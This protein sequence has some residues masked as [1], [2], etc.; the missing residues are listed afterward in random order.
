[1]IEECPE[2]AYEELLVSKME[3]LLII[4]SESAISQEKESPLAHACGCGGKALTMPVH[5]VRVLALEIEK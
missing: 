5:T 4:K 3:L 1:M 2:F